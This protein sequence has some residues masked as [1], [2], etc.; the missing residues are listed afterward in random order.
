M[1]Q[2]LS[3]MNKDGFE[4]ASAAAR[5]AMTLDE[6]LAE[7]HA[8]MGSIRALSDRNW[9][10]A[11]RE[12]RRALELNPSYAPA[13]QWYSVL[14][15]A[16][17]GR[18]DE[19]VAEIERAH[20]LDPLSAIIETDRGFVHYLRREYSEAIG[21]LNKALELDPTFVPAHFRLSYVYGKLGN[22]DKFIKEKEAISR[23]DK[24]EFGIS[25][26]TLKRVYQS[27]GIRGYQRLYEDVYSKTANPAG[28]L[29]LM[30]MDGGDINGAFSI[31]FT[32]A[33]RHDLSLFYLFV[34]PEFD[35]LRSDARFKKLL[36]RVGLP[37]T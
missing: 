12:F 14:Y 19:A 27:E 20:D 9:P 10:E 25:E 34:D 1:L 5:H 28:E 36:Q 8:S 3:G 24:R 32:L 7:A 2:V 26:D 35:P 13:H 6:N 33:D 16:P 31:Y 17:V 4:L 11:E 30:R 18:L 29:G 23:I 15:L 22:F 37:S 21:D